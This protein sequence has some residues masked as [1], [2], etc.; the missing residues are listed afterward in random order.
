M[1]EG[2]RFSNARWN[3]RIFSLT[4]SAVLTCKFGFI[5]ENYLL[6]K[7]ER[8]K[9][10]A[11]FFLLWERQTLLEAS[12]L[13]KLIQVEMMNITEFIKYQN[14]R[15]QGIPWSLKDVDVH[16][17]S[18]YFSCLLWNTYHSYQALCY[19]LFSRVCM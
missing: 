5:K 6:D 16:L 18:Y 8:E 10:L 11:F 13:K 9:V 17:F 1:K 2:K 12:Y 19:S 14:I 4:R 3:R 7:K 15:I